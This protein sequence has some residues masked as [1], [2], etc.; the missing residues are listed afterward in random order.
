MTITKACGDKR[1]YRHPKLCRR[2]WCRNVCTGWA[3]CF[4]FSANELC[5]SDQLCTYAAVQCTFRSHTNNLPLMAR[6]CRIHTPLLLT[7]FLNSKSLISFSDKY[8]LLCQV[9][10]TQIHKM[11]MVYIETLSILKGLPQ[12]CIVAHMDN[13]QHLP[14]PNNIQSYVQIQECTT[15]GDFTVI[16]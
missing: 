5:T 13:H 2:G 1:E 7:C 15:N 16:R 9:Y 10:E 4:I 14:L 8:S 3:M 11:S 12:S 6:C